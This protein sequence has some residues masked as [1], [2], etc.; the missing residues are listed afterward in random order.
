MDG[1]TPKP[2]NLKLLTAVLSKYCTK[3]NSPAGCDHSSGGQSGMVARAQQ[4]LGDVDR[5]RGEEKGGGPVDPGRGEESINE[6]NTSSTFAMDTVVTAA[7]T[8]STLPGTLKGRESSSE[9]TPL[10]GDHQAEDEFE[11]RQK[12]ATKR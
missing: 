9:R 8:A 6:Q 2:I 3:T 10:M 12:D 5:G 11:V 4:P 7:T 1:F